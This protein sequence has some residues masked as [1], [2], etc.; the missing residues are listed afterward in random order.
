MA[1]GE[2]DVYRERFNL[3][4]TRLNRNRELSRTQDTGSPLSRG[5][6]GIYSE[7]SVLSGAH[8]PAFGVLP[9]LRRQ[10][11]SALGSLLLL[12]ISFVSL[13]QR[14]TTAEREAKIH[15]KASSLPE[16]FG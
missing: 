2:R 3:L 10:T 11:S 1:G 14:G 5:T 12:L 16:D 4:V 15:R 6:R 8:V 7:H 9:S 13:H